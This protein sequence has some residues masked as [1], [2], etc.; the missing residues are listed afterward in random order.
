MTDYDV[1]ICGLGPV[2][3]LL[4]LLL[5]DHGRANARLRPRAT[6]PTR[7]RAPPSSTTRS[8]GSSRPSASTPPILAD[9]QVHARASILTVRRPAGR[10]L[11][12][13]HVGR[14]GHPPL[15]SINQPAMERTMLAALAER[16]TVEHPPRPDA[17]GRSTG[18]RAGV[19]VYVRP[20]GGGRSERVSGRFL[21]GC[22]GASSAV[23]T[24]LA[25]PV[26]RAHRA[27]ALDR[28]RR[29]R[30]PP[31]APG[32]AAAV[33]RPRRAADGDAADVARPPPLGVDAAPGRG[34]RTPHLDPAAV[35]RAVASGSTASARRS[36]A[37]SSTRS[38]RGWRARGAAAGSCSPATPPT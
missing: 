6:S 14:L 4:A 9:A 20:T 3:Q 29:A 16:P 33:R 31:P 22:D 21:V 34:R 36:S 23:R 12:G 11:P 7:C 19:D 32:A 25:G 13:S 24:R 5:G 35:R 18:A 2:G 15:V 37:R 38:T 26:R 8:C 27:A 30:R 17:R 28:R 10:V 1:I